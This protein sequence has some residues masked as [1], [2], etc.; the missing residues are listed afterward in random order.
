MAS[1]N[2]PP[3]FRGRMFGLKGD[4]NFPRL[5]RDGV[6]C[7]S[8]AFRMILS[9]GPRSIK[10]IIAILEALNWMPKT[11]GD[12]GHYIGNNLGICCSKK[13]KGNDRIERDRIGDRE[14]YGFYRLRNRDPRLMKWVA[15]NKPEL[16]HSNA[17]DI[18]TATKS[19][20]EHKPIPKPVS[21]KGNGSS[22]AS[23]AVSPTEHTMVIGPLVG[24]FH[25]RLFGKSQPL[26]TVDFE[27]FPSGD[28]VRGLGRR[29]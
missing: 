22:K 9:G 18:I 2:R 29:G 14:N 8:D 4:P 13:A 26:F 11:I 21:D 3:R 5:A 16:L 12:K 10:E 24:R 25:V 20:S 28:Q 1:G 7:Q 17:L 27:L 19:K 6:P 23:L 15:E